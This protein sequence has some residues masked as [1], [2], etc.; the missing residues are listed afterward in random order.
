[1]PS[2]CEPTRITS[3]TTE[4]S[5]GDRVTTGLLGTGDSSIPYALRWQLIEERPVV[6]ELLPFASFPDGGSPLPSIVDAEPVVAPWL[7]H[8]APRPRSLGPVEE[9]LWT[10][11]ATDGLPFIVRCLVVWRRLEVKSR[12]AG[13]DPAVLGASVA[14][15][16]AERCGIETT[17]RSEAERH[18]V[19]DFAVSHVSRQLQTL[20]RGMR[21]PLW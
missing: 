21:S 6:V 11:V 20:V 5:P 14:L 12:L 10:R 16:C 4:T 19:S 13:V 15:V 18:G 2:G 9:E 3:S 1:M 7:T 8:A 17:V